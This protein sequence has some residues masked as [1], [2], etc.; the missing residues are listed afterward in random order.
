MRFVRSVLRVLAKLVPS[1]YTSRRDRLSAEGDQLASMQQFR[2]D[3]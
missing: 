1:N 2:G 3:L